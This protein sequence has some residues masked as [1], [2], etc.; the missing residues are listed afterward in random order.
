MD[1]LAA[2]SRAFQDVK[3]ELELK[4]TLQSNGNQRQ[5]NSETSR[6]IEQLLLSETSLKQDLV[7]AFSHLDMMHVAN[8]RL[9]KESRNSLQSDSKDSNF[10]AQLA[11]QK[12]H[13]EAMKRQELQTKSWQLK[14]EELIESQLKLSNDLSE[15]KT[16][17]EQ[18]Q[19]ELEKNVSNTSKIKQ[20]RIE[21]D[22]MEVDHY[23]ATKNLE[24]KI[25][26][27]Q[28]LSNESIDSNA[29]LRTNLVEVEKEKKTLESSL[30]ALNLK[31]NELNDIEALKNEHLEAQSWLQSQ[32]KTLK[33]KSEEYSR[34]NQQLKNDINA[35][36]KNNAVLQNSL[37][38]Y[39]AHVTN[40]ETQ[41]TSL[42]SENL[43][44]KKG[45]ELK[46]K[47]LRDATGNSTASASN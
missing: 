2:Q 42:Q 35:I 26:H 7:D 47:L 13:S 15:S 46:S 14:T 16:R 3:N 22:T 33:M 39:D 40:I 27:L 30:S 6:Q 44:L 38:E 9:K 21:M 43:A 31:S 8:K 24:S 20:F 17:T 37:D 29:Q 25:K 19:L 23:E 18:L 5:N 11:I 41:Y 4:L 1:K 12:E 36:E 32:I 28:Q 34:S 45:L 10:N